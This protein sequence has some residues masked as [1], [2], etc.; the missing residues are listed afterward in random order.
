MKLQ[1]WDELKKY[2]DDTKDETSLLSDDSKTTILAVG[3]ATC[4]IAAGAKE[5]A[6]A[7]QAEIEKQKLSNVKIIATGCYGCCY[8]EPMVEVRQPGKD[9]VYYGYV[10]PDIAK[11]IVSKHVANNEILQGNVLNMEVLIP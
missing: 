7:L 1:S 11:D 10:T 4:G 2:R 6:D 3:E 5:V 9:S 8:A